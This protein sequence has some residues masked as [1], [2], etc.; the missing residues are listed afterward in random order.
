LVPGCVGTTYDVDV[1]TDDMEEVYDGGAEKAGI[2][3]VSTQENV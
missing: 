1:L 3:A 2:V